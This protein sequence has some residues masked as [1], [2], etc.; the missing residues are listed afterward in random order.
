MNKK[1]DQVKY[2]KKNFEKIIKTFEKEKSKAERKQKFEFLM[3]QISEMQLY[4]SK[5]RQTTL[6]EEMPMPVPMPVDESE[7][8][9]NFRIQPSPELVEEIIASQQAKEE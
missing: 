7:T 3:G 9:S 1:K 2:L 8:G 5:S 4:I 6:P